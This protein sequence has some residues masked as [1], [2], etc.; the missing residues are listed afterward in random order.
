MS[1]NRQR[2]SL[3]AVWIS[4]RALPFWVQVWVAGVLVPVNTAAFFLTDTRTGMAAA[5]AAVFVVITNVP[6]MLYEGGMS[7]LMAVPH[8]FAW[9][10]L[11]IFIVG[12]LQNF[13]GGPMME[14]KE[15]I[16]A[17]LLLVVNGISLVFDAIDTVRWC[18]GERKVPGHN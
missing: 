4:W 16:F 18:R 12:R 8:L 11:W 14:S 2:F 13:F 9:I 15:F 5:I 10:P 17:L 1:D 6:I 3:A 7:R